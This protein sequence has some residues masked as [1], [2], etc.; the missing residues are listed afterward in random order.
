MVTLDRQLDELD[1]A[2][3][4]LLQTDG[5]ISNREIAHQLGI[6]PSTSLERMRSLRDRGYLLGFT[7]EVDL[8]LLGRTVEAIISVSLRPQSRTIIEGFRKFVLDLTETIAVFVVTGDDD[9]LIHVAVPSTRALQDFVLDRLT[10]RP[11]IGGVKTSVLYEHDAKRVV[12]AMN[13]V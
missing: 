8:A 1:S 10:Q 6:A 9:V 4:R 11:E 5:R 12:G 7:A 13:S 3:L 2:L